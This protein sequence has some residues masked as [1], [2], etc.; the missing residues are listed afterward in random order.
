MLIP[1]GNSTI[2][3]AAYTNA[4]APEEP[5][6][7]ADGV[8]VTSLNRAV[9]AEPPPDRLDGDTDPTGRAPKGPPEEKPEVL[10]KVHDIAILRVA[11][12]A[13]KTVYGFVTD[14]KD[15]FSQF[16]LAP[17]EM[18][19][20]VRHTAKAQGLSENDLDPDGNIGIFVTE[21]RLGFGVSCSS[22]VCQR[23]ATALVQVF[24]KLFDG[25]GTS[26]YT[27]R[28]GGTSGHTKIGSTR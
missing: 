5:S 6:D 18:W 9:R 25:R 28:P 8:A 11:A 1:T 14:L 2:S 26:C 15:F 16:C 7:D 4:S 20:S 19:K 10:A 13:F 24:R 23:F 21:Y 17:E 3:A 22:K 27:S 12:K